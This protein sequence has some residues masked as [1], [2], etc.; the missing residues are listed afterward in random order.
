LADGSWR[1]YRLI[2]PVL[3]TTPK[4]FADMKPPGYW[5]GTLGR[6]V[7]VRQVSEAEFWATHQQD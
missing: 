2:P 6:F 3:D 5:S 1:P 7:E 4:S